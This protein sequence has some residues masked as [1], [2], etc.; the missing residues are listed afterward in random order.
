MKRLQ[1]A[2]LDRTALLLLKWCQRINSHASTRI[3]PK[4][5]GVWAS[6][7]CLSKSGTGLHGTN[8]DGLVIP[9][10]VPKFPEDVINME[11]THKNFTR[12]FMRGT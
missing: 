4:S 1:F 9:L 2:K 10:A 7:D 11:R 12:L 6:K 5:W 8:F 3:P